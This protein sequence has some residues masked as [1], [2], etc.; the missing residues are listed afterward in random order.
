MTLILSLSAIIH[1]GVSPVMRFFVKLKFVHVGGVRFSLFLFETV[2]RNCTWRPGTVIQ[3]KHA[4]ENTEWVYTVTA[5]SMYVPAVVMVMF[6]CAKWRKCFRSRTTVRGIQNLTTSVHI[7][8]YFCVQYGNQG[9][10]DFNHLIGFIKLNYWFKSKTKTNQN[11]SRM[12]TNILY[13][14]IISSKLKLITK[15][16]IK[17]LINAYR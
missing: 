11:L 14:Q 4:E 3:Q 15:L 5:C 1:S 9:S 16:K 17:T 6:F 2:R 8:F 10:N 13:L 12:K 7:S